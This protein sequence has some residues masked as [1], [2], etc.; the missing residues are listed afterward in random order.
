[1]NAAHT[2]VIL[3]GYQNDY[4]APTGILHKVI[5]DSARVTGTLKNTIDLIDRLSPTPALLISTPI[6]F[7]EDYRELMDPV[8]ILKTIKEL[9][10][11]QMGTPGAK[12]IAEIRRFGDRILEVP[13]K[14]GLNAFSNTALDDVLSQH[15]ISHVAIAGAVTSICVD[16]T[17]RAASEKGYSVVVLSDCTVGRTLFEQEFYCQSILPLYAEVTDH[18]DFVRRLDGAA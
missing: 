16:S 3:I 10:A 8:G 6:A 4:F 1:M 14:R 15:A 2:A 11:F 13:G 12:T 9:G 7:T 18:M 5:E 17:G